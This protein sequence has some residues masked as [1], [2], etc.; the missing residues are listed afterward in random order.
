MRLCKAIDPYESVSTFQAPGC[1]DR[2]MQALSIAHVQKV[3]VDPAATGQPFFVSSHCGA[4]DRV[5][6]VVQETHTLEVRDQL[7]RKLDALSRQFRNKSAETGNVST[8]TREA[9]NNA[10]AKAARRLPPS[11]SELS[12]WPA[13]QPARLAFLLSRSRP[14]ADERVHRPRPQTVHRNHPRIDIRLCSSV[15]RHTP[16]P[17]SPF[18]KAVKLSALSCGEIVS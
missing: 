5:A 4:I 18:R 3:G 1:I 10:D 8:R 17:P 16:A 14:P 2:A 12:S 11:Q 7:L 6:H 15:P 13:W 9:G